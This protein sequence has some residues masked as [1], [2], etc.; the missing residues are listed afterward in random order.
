VLLD[1]QIQV[2]GGLNLQSPGTPS[3]T[4]PN[5]LGRIVPPRTTSVV[6]GMDVSLQRNLTLQ[7]RYS[8]ERATGVFGVTQTRLGV[9]R[10][11]YA[12]GPPV[13]GTLPDGRTY[14]VATW[15]P[16]QQAIVAGG[17]GFEL[18]RWPG[19][20]SGY[21]GLE[22]GLGRRMEGRFGG[23]VSVSLN[24]A[25]ES[26]SDEGRYDI[27]GNPTLT[28]TEPLVDGGPYAPLSGQTFLHARWQVDATGS[29]R[30]PYG[31]DF[32]SSLHARQGY[33]FIPFV[34]AALG[35]DALSVVLLP[36]ET[37][38][39]P[40][41]RLVDVRASRRF[42]AGRLDATLGLDLFNTDAALVRVR[43]ASAANYR[44]LTSYVSPR[45]ARLS[46]R[47]GF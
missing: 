10:G 46:L 28:D 5:R 45:I 13:R 36:V 8:Q 35:A 16:S 4:S 24:D 21:R 38:R 37:Y 2:G 25:E 32:A 43:N 17:G 7:V 1:Q 26:Y 34:Q 30:L 27:F 20:A 9:G 19:Y 33:P 47:I 14:N 3:S 31:V 22:F 23:R 6:A 41:L 18:G 11:D 42:T 15:I 39:Y 44:Q 40:A 12:P 29:V